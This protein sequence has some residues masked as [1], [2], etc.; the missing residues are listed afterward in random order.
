[1]RKS[2]A[3]P[4]LYALIFAGLLGWRVRAWAAKRRKNVTTQNKTLL[5]D[6]N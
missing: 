1:M 5:V 6:R 3:K 4:Y 2:E